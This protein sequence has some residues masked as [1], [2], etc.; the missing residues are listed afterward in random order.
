MKAAAGRDRIFMNK[1]TAPRIGHRLAMAVAV[2]GAVF[3]VG[4]APRAQPGATASPW[5]PALAT[6]GRT[7]TQLPGG[8]WISI[9]G[10]GVASDRAE[11]VHADGSQTPLG[12]RLAHPRTAHSA[13]VLPDGRVLVLGGVD[14]VGAVVAEPEVFEPETRRFRT[15][16]IKELLPRAHH[17]ATVLG[18]GRVLI[19]GGVDGDGRAV[20]DVELWNPATGSVETLDG[21]LDV[22]RLDHRASLLPGGRLLV[23]GGAAVDGTP[24]AAAVIID[25]GTGRIDAMNSADASQLAAGLEGTQ[26]PAIENTTPGP[27]AID[28]PGARPLVLRFT[29]RMA[30]ASLSS[31]SCTLVGP[32]GAEPVVVTP[33]DDGLIAFVWPTRELLPASRYTLFIKGPTDT[34]HRALALTAIGFDTAAKPAGTIS[35]P[36]IAL[37]DQGQAQ[38]LARD[39]QLRRL[40]PAEQQI[41]QIADQTTESEDWVP[42]PRNFQGR[43]HAD[44]ADAALEQ[45]PALQAPAG[46]TALSGRVLGMNGR[47]V[48]G[49]TLRVGDH[50]VRSD[51]T[52]R[53]LLPDL[54]PGAAKMEIDGATADQG[55]T[56][57]GYYAARIELAARQTTVVPY[58]IWMLRLDPA[59]TVRIDAP[60]TGE[61]IIRS[62]RIPGLELHIPA[63][64][65]IRDRHGQIVNELNVTAIPVDRPPFPVPDLGVPVYFTVQPGGAVLESVTGVPGQGARLFYPNFNAEAPGARGAFWN[66]DPDDRGWF[67]YGM[68]TITHD[69]KQAVPDDGVVIHELTGAMFDG[70]NTPGGNGP[71]PCDC[72]GSGGDPVSLF[73]GQFDHH[74]HDMRVSDVVPIDVE[75][76]YDSADKNRR[77]F[78]IGMSHGYDAFLF[79]QNQYQEVDLVLP[80]GTRV[81]YARTSPGTGFHDAV[82]TSTAPGPWANS[83]VARN[84]DR[85]G[86]D[87]VFRDGRKWFFFQFQPLSEMTD[88]NGNVTRIVR[89]T[90]GVA[91]KVKQI[92]SPNGRTVAF[93]YNAA[94]FISTLTD[95]LGR[96]VHYE[97]DAAGHLTEVVD[98]LGG[99][100]DYTWDPTNHVVT[101]I[102]DANGALYVKNEYD[103]GGRVITQTL[104]DDSTFKFAY[105]TANGVTTQTE[106]TDRR[107]SIRRVQFDPAGCVVK[108]TFP[109]GL[110]EEQVTT[111]EV[112]DGRLRASVDALGRRT[113]YDYDAAGNTTRVTRL[114]GSSQAVSATV[115]YDT[116][117]SQPITITDANG[118]TTQLTYDSKGNLISVGNPLGE[119]A[120]FSYDA[121]GRPLTRSDALGRTTTLGYDGADLATVTDPL[122]RQGQYFNDTIG[123]VIA[124]VDPLGNRSVYDWSDL[125]RPLSI[126]DP[127]GGTTRFAYDPTGSMLGHTDANNHTTTYTYNAAGKVETI[128]DA[129]AHGE[130]RSYEPGG[131]I[132]QF[133]DR[134]GQLGAVAYDTLGR[135]RLLS[136]GA[137]ADAPTAFKSQVENTWDAG[138]RLTQIVDRTCGVG[139]D[140]GTVTASQTITRSYDDLDRRIREVTPQGEVDYTYDRGGRR[141][142]VVIK[143]G[144]P[145]SQAV[146]PA[147]TYAYDDANRLIRILQA[148][149]A[150]NG[151]Q[152]QEISFAYDAA[153]QRTLV[154][155]ANGCTIHYAYDAARNQT[156]IVYKRS[157]GALLGDLQ[158][159]YDAAG[160]RISMGGSLARI[161]LPT[162]DV[163]DAAY[164]ANNRL[165]S[166]AGQPYTY[167][168][169]GNLTS[170][171][172]SSYR[173]DER[174]RLVSIAQSADEIARFQYDG[175]GRR[176]GATLESQTT[177]YLYDGAS[178][179]QELEGTDDTAAVKTHLVN[180]GTDDTVLR[181]EGHDGAN[182]LSVFGDSNHSTVMLLDAAEAQ[183]GSYSYGPYGETTAETTGANRQQYTGRENDHPGS[184]Q[185]LYYYRARYYAPGLGRFISEDPI[186]WLSGQAN[187]Y[188]Y[189]GGDPIDFRDPTGLD[190][191][192]SFENFSAGLGD[193]LTF[194]LTRA[195]RAGLGINGV[196]PCAGW[197]AAGGIAGMVV[198]VVATVGVSAELQA[199]EKTVDIYRAVGVREFED[200]MANQAF[201]AGTNSM[202]AR[203]F[204]L[205]LE[206]AL[207][208]A[209]TDL[210]KVAILKATIPEAVLEMFEFSRNIDVMIFKSGVVTVQP[211]LLE[212]LNSSI[213]H[214]EHAL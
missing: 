45:L 131:Q 17:S 171:G 136:F 47:A 41:L 104:A 79:S 182:Q 1:R 180:A 66:Y 68:G 135:P 190:F 80:N 74:E 137:T 105:T 63:G 176:T 78:G 95:N 71:P 160:R 169:G 212:L 59:G 151:N 121:Q 50:E 97:Y 140:C 117:F 210:S 170:D 8:S 33:V 206:D 21:H 152:P 23:S 91:G 141:T 26:A 32:A 205:T 179:I 168:A 43:W 35:A 148:A 40:A 88:A 87:L 164:D 203:Q 11:L 6:T 175:H 98:P 101:Q 53:F 84:D 124:V 27:E 58:V 211:E 24:A 57:Y 82:F 127:M 42:G 20:R 99:K 100:R 123:R 30:M 81:H 162:A 75:R 195:L 129:L 138:N 61:T 83:I 188:A 67:V 157:N 202:E 161:T 89:E 126:T 13:T 106:L 187:N 115:T 3:A 209:E 213:S 149:G 76:T 192:D 85:V 143:N 174:D 150:I 16:P 198:G 52:G 181:L 128:R 158:Y 118:N 155:L 14:A 185:G 154:T 172:T 10:D 64:T 112:D 93:T 178:V 60:T 114:A 132:R 37:A 86:W 22:A 36:A 49:V 120:T 39:N 147:I 28:V 119:V 54:Q 201:R 7:V 25:P 107:G 133:I 183:V 69:A 142:A 166:W 173:W 38:A 194:G 144:P 130:T 163:T 48:P 9:G 19:A 186:G 96:V 56:H 193:S 134:N 200:V 51:I 199:A 139:L 92:I 4:E 55:A 62:P 207:A 156:A 90:D 208:Y 159:E 65:V 73:T 44:R 145:G 214:I 46:I 18:D 77:A 2:A 184:G 5:S 103:S 191:W 165:V 196:N 102:H 34:A 113:E 189:A 204:A 197:Y 29:K 153:G 177:G 167:D 125:D 146:Q 116:A 72:G 12:A 110:P 15:E 111:Y 122:G 109:A 108:N 94:G 70:G 31:Q